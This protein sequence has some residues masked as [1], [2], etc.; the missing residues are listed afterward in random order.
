MA[1]ELNA[2]RAI[3]V[4]ADALRPIVEKIEKRINETPFH[5]EWR[6]DVFEFTSRYLD[7]IGDDIQA[8]TEDVNGGLNGVLANESSDSDTWR[9]ATRLEMHM[10]R[11]LDSYDELRGSECYPEDEQGL[12][13]LIEVYQDVLFQ[14]L[15]WLNEI[16]EFAEDPVAALRRRGLATE[17]KVEL[18]IGLTLKPPYQM[19]SMT[20]WAEQ[21]AAELALPP[22]VPRPSHGLVGL[23]LA[24]AFGLGWMFGK[25][26]E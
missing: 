13:L 11:L 14:I 1:E 17:G 8:L 19:E 7:K 24:T 15:G 18:N 6:D 16:L 2:H 22:P 9:A 26:D 20:R 23:G 25:D 12:S 10:E 4:L 21:R 5:R 3:R